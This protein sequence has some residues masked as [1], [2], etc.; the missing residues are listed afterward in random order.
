MHVF[1]TGGIQV[2]KST[3]IDKTLSLLKITPGGFRTYFG[4]DR[5]ASDRFLYMSSAVG[6]KLFSV[7]NAVAYFA[8]GKAPQAF[9]RRFDTYGVE[10][11]RSA[12][13]SSNLIIMDECGSLER[14]A[15]VFQKEVIDALDGNTPVFGVIK[16]SSGGWT[17]RIRNHPKVRLI[18]VTVNNRDVLPQRIACL[19][20]NRIDIPYVP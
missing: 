19:F 16:Q 12:G 5:G 14:G 1:L 13:N 18:T 6:A 7:K 8:E 10:L 17:D 11:I 20:T 3:I 9:T 15:L 4:S 2:G